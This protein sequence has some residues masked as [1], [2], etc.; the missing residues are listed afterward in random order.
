MHH[1][2]APS[3]IFNNVWFSYLFYI[4][5]V[6]DYFEEFVYEVPAALYDDSDDDDLQPSPLAVRLIQK[7]T[8]LVEQ[9]N[10]KKFILELSNQDELPDLFEYQPPK[11]VS[12]KKKSLEKNMAIKIVPDLTAKQLAVEV[13]KDVNIGNSVSRSVD[14]SWLDSSDS[15]EDLCIV[16]MQTE[17][18]FKVNNSDSDGDLPDLNK[19]QCSVCNNLFKHEEIGRHQNACKDLQ[20]TLANA[21]KDDVFIVDSTVGLPPDDSPCPVCGQMVSDAFLLSHTN[22]CLNRQEAAQLGATTSYAS[23]IGWARKRTM[24]R[25][26][27]TSGGVGRK[28]HKGDTPYF[29]ALM[30][31]LTN[32]NVAQF[33]PFSSQ[34]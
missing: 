21:P 13:R 22:V 1:L 33:N 12:P 19:V 25:K 2:H 4:F 9:S 10:M 3:T 34:V 26:R 31:Q 29:Q 32:I 16:K 24:K 28:Q 8:S 20:Q 23:H 14:H 11:K 18:V 15:D 5:S 27:G 7:N 6:L 17:Q 30:N